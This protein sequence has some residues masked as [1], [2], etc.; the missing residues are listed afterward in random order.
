MRADKFIFYILLHS[1]TE[2]GDDGAAHPVY[3][4]R[5]AVAVDACQKC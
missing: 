5:N 4:V 2:G 3:A 1:V